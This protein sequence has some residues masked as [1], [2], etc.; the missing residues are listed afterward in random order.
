MFGYNYQKQKKNEQDEI[1]KKYNIGAY[2]TP[3]SFQNTG[4]VEAVN[5]EP[6]YYLNIADKVKTYVTNV[7][8]K[9]Y[10]YYDTLELHQKILKNKKLH[11]EKESKFLS[12]VKTFVEK[13]NVFS[14]KLS[15]S[16]TMAEADMSYEQMMSFYH[17]DLN[18]IKTEQTLALEDFQVKMVGEYPE[19]P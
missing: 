19:G 10:T 18:I 2:M 5:I 14:S 4:Y 6:N 13:L 7:L 12:H 8:K 1:H 16:T 17:T 11:S 15:N 9:D 3:Y